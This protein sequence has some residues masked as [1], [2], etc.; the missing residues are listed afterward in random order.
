MAEVDF[1]RRAHGELEQTR[2]RMSVMAGAF[3]A[4]KSS[5]GDFSEQ[6]QRL[7]ESINSYTENSETL[8]KEAAGLLAE[9]KD[10]HAKS[11]LVETGKKM[12][13]LVEDIENEVSEFNE[14]VK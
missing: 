14:K 9:G 6:Y 1:Y 10:L 7:N 4:K 11:L 5:A 8:L 2:R 12:R 3:E 13:A